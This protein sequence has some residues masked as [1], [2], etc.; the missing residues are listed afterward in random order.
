MP[1]ETFDEPHS[2]VP[3]EA[4][5]EIP[6]VQQD[7]GIIFILFPKEIK[8]AEGSSM[9]ERGRPKGFS[10]IP[11]FPGMLATSTCVNERY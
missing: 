4:A 8:Q 9:N 6:S 5:H 7:R 10:R 1:P 3:D 11:V 2:E